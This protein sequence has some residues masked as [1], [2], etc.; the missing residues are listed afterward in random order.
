VPEPVRIL[1]RLLG[2]ILLVAGV[3]CAVLLV[4][5]GPAEIADRLGATCST[6][7]GRSRQQCDWFQAADLL[8]TGCWIA[9]ILGAVLRLVTRP[10]GKGPRVLDLRRRR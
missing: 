5:P 10:A 9:V 1:L 6:D 7:G 2:L 4:W 3:I 8:W